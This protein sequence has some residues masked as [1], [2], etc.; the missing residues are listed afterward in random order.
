MIL[1]Y[2]LSI[3]GGITYDQISTLSIN[4][5]LVHRHHLYGHR[6]LHD[7]QMD[8]HPDGSVPDSRVGAELHLYEEDIYGRR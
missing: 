4:H 6:T 7:E 1:C 5:L 8:I 2:T 3:N